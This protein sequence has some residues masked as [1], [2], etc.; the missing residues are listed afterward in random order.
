MRALAEREVIIV[1]EEV[2]LRVG[3]L[4]YKNNNHVRHRIAGRRQQRHMRDGAM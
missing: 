1:F 4:S 3:E 2:D